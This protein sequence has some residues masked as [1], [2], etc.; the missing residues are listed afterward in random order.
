MA[1]AGCDAIELGSDAVDNGQLGRLVKSFDAE[2]VAELTA[3]AWKPVCRSVR[4]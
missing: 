1:R 3:I 2:R 4:Q